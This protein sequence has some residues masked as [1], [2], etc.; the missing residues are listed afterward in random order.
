MNMASLTVEDARLRDAV[1]RRL[2]HTSGVGDSTI[3]V[4]VDEGLVTLTG[5]VG[6]DAGRRAAERTAKRVQ[7]VWAV[8]NDLM[9]REEVDWTEADVEPD[10]TQALKLRPALQRTFR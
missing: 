8:V 2:A 9:V 4:S 1:L 5:A 3:D 7:G 10:A 6:S